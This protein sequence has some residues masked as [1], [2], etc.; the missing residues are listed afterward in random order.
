MEAATR[1][2]KYLKGTVGQGIWLHSEPTNILT[3]WCDSEWAACPNIRRSITRYVIKFGNSL[4]S[5]KSKK[6]QT[7]SRSSAEDEYRNMASAVSEITWVLGLFKELG[8]S[9][10]LPITVSVTVNQ[11]SNWQ[12]TQYFMK[13]QNISR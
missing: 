12:L 10:Q 4:V 5:W 1:V 8:I 13:R 9:I 2:V 3:C 7:V 11:P 6:Q